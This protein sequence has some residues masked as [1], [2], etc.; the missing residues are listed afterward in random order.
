[1]YAKHVIN[2]FAKKIFRCSF[3]FL[4]ALQASQSPDEDEGVDTNDE[5]VPL[6]SGR[7]SGKKKYKQSSIKFLRTDHSFSN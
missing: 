1:M 3:G 2:H 6:F 7:F 4:Q 5:E